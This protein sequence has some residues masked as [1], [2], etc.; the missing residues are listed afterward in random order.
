[1]ITVLAKYAEIALKGKN[2]YEFELKLLENIKLNAKAHNLNLISAKRE[3]QVI[4]IK[5]ED[6]NPKQK[7]EEALKKVFGIA[8]FS[9]VE[10]IQKDENTIL[11]KAE[12][13]LKLF[14]KQGIKT[15]AF[16]TKRTDKNFPLTSPQLNSKMGEI[17]QNLKLK[18]NYKNFEE[19]IFIEIQFRKC[20]IH[21]GKIQG[22]GGLPVGTS[23][24]VLVLLSGG[25]DSPVAANL[26]MKKGL[27]C[28][29]FHLH[30][31]PK[32][33]NVMDTKMKQIIEQLNKFQFESKLYLI[34]YSFYEFSTQNQIPQRYELVFFKHFIF[35]MAEKI[36]LENGYDAIVSGDSL[37]QVASQTIENIKAT[38]FGIRIPIFRPLL[39]YDK[40]EIINI[41]KKIGTYELSIEKYK[42]CCSLVSQN[43]LTQTNLEKFEQITKEA[44]IIELLTS[45]SQKKEKFEIKQI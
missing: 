1:M 28:D 12:I 22:A 10:E 8:N 5:Y 37:N 38:S 39:T 21:H 32:N 35:K 29:F 45:I 25:I 2:R 23:G 18:T 42:D 19:Q 17:A 30:T 15:V 9:F 40:D 24:K 14:K 34:P 7:I 11:E 16:K 13:I 20:F 3:K 43:P 44:H 33:Q 4:L 36:A 41:A 6:N 31:Y 27:T 26:I